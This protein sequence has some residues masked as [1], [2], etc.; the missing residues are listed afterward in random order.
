MRFLRRL[1]SCASRHICTCLIEGAS[2]P[3]RS[4][5][6]ALVYFWSMLCGMV[7]FEVVSISLYLDD[8]VN[9]LSIKIALDAI[10]IAFIAIDSI[11]SLHLIGYL[12]KKCIKRRFSVEND[13]DFPSCYYNPYYWE[14]VAAA[15][16]G[17]IVTLIVI[18]GL[19]HQLS[20]P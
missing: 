2:M 8:P 12:A 7:F 19:A 10:V 6:R 13:G 11:I 1:K 17:P 20:R 14:A 18:V 15:I 9:N 3:K 16:L 5:I 4:F